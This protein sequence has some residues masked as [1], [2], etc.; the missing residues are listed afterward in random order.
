M[1]LIPELFVSV[2]VDFKSLALLFQ[3]LELFF[4]CHDILPRYSVKLR[5]N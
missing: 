3:P 2:Q 1:R 5:S 4:K